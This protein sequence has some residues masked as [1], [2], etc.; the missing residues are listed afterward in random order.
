MR[1]GHDRIAVTWR[2]LE[3]VGIA[4]YD[5]HH[6]RYAVAQDEPAV[7]G[8]GETSCSKVIMQLSTCGVQL[9]TA[10]MLRSSARESFS[11][12]QGLDAA[13]Q[14]VRMGEPRI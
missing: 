9:A 5:A 13:S 11:G 2:M 1:H 10:A 7:I 4:V 14:A 12:A 8:L 6:H 3:H